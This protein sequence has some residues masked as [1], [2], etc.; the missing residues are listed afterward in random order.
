MN[1][2]LQPPTLLDPT[3]RPAR[4]AIDRACPRCGA[5]PEKRVLSAGF[6]S[7][8]DVCSACGHDFDERTL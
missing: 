7:P 1:D 5:P 6:G 4:A 8:H 2:Q 3:G